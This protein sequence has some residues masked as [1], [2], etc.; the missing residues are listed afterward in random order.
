MEWVN[1]YVRTVKFVERGREETRADCWGLVRLIYKNELNV[2]L[3][4]FLDYKTTKQCRK[5]TKMMDEER[6]MNWEEVSGS[7]KPFDVILIREAGFAMHVGVV[8][9][10][11]LMVHCQNGSDT[12]VANYKTNKDW[13]SK[14]EGIYR[15]ARN[16][17]S[18]STVPTN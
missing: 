4:S 10:K 3:P 15:Y 17:D 11:G 5:I 7:E 13:T 16:S 2:D 1:H 6:E 8:I 18:A 9:G 12:T 14:V